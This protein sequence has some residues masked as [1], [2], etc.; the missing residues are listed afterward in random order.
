MK[1]D[2]GLSVKVPIRYL[3]NKCVWGQESWLSTLCYHFI[4][5]LFIRHFK[6]RIMTQPSSVDIFLVLLWMVWSIAS[7]IAVTIP[8]WWFGRLSCCI[9]Y[10]ITVCCDDDGENRF[11]GNT[12][13]IYH[14]FLSYS[15]LKNLCVK[16]IINNLFGHYTFQMMLF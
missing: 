2:L 1:F 10:S 4:Y 15:F 5:Y 7:S 14:C 3:L 9:Y 11:T 8:S 6:S 13:N 12:F 16:N